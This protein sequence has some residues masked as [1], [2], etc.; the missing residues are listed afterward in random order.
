MDQVHL[1]LIIT[2]LPIFG[3]ILGALVLGFGIWSK[4]DETKMAAYLLFV[5][6]AIGTGI[7]YITG[8]ETEEIVEKIPGIAES[9]I[10]KHSEFAEIA[11]I[12]LIILGVT[13]LIALVITYKKSTFSAPTS[14]IMLFVSLVSFVLVART[15]Y[16]GGQIRHTEIAT[17]TI[18][19]QIDPEN[20]EKDD[21]D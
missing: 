13:S 11:L 8:E 16:L 6:A 7:A 10:E 5:I 12:G 4:S 19:N 3:S 21:D 17:G 20:T 18:Q 9:I 14:I 2:H 15:G 1:H